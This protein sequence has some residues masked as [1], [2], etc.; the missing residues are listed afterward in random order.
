MLST[1][2]FVYV[3]SLDANSDRQ[4][5]LFRCNNNDT[6]Q[7][8]YGSTLLGRKISLFTDYSKESAN[9]KR[10]TYQKLV[11]TDEMTTIRFETS[12]SF[13]FYYTETGCDVVC[14]QFYI[15]VNPQLKVGSGANTQLLDLNAIQCQTVLTKSLGQFPTWKSKLEV[16]HKTGYNMIHF[17]PIQELG[18]SNSSYSLADQL[19]LNPIFNTKE[20]ECRVEDVQQFIEWL[21]TEWQILSLTDIVLNHTANESPWLQTHPE[22]AFNCFNS[23]WLRPA[24]LLDRILYRMTTDIVDDRWKSKGLTTEVNSEDHL[25]LIRK[26]LHEEYL[27]I[28]NIHELY[29]VDIDTTLNEFKEFLIK[30]CKTSKPEKPLNDETLKLEI[31]VDDKYRRFKSTIDLNIALKIVLNEVEFNGDND[32]WINWSTDN[33]R[34]KLTILNEV[35]TNEIRHHLSDAIENVIKTARYERIDSWGPKHKIISL[36]CPLVCNYFTHKGS[37]MD[38]LDEQKLAFD[39][40]DSK[41][42]MAHNGWVMGDDPLRNFAEKGCNV[43]IRRELIAWGDSVKLNYGSGPQDCP[44]LWSHM[45]KYVTQMA[46]IF[47]GLRLDNCH[48]TPIH[49]AQ[50]LIDSA[51][52]V[53]PNLYLIAELF[54][55]HEGLDNIFVNKLGINSLIREGLSAHDSHDLGRQVYRFGGEPIGAFPPERLS[56]GQSELLVLPL[57]PSVCHAIFFDVTHDN[58]SPIIKRSAYDPLASSALV[59]MTFSAIG[60]NRGHDELVPHHIN[61]VHETREYKSWKENLDSDDK[62]IANNSLSM[63][64][65]IIKSKLAFN[66]LHEWLAVNGYS[67]QFVDQR[68]FDTVAVT[69]HNPET[70]ESVVLVAR[71]AFHCPKDPKASPYLPPLR[72]DGIIDK[73]LFETHMTG[74]PEI[75]FVQ[76]K[77]YINGYSEIRSDIRTDLALDDSKLIKANKIGDSYEIIFNYFP[78][79]AVIAFKVSLSDYHKNALEKLRVFS[80][81]LD[82]ESSDVNTII[83]NLS[84]ID[85]NYLLF[86]C[87]HEEHDDTNGGA[88]S[89]PVFGQMNYCGIASIIYYLRHIR[90]HNDL[91]H[92][93]CGNLR[94]GNWLMDYI[95]DRLTKNPNTKSFADWLAKVFTSLSQIPRYLIPRYFDSIITRI[96]TSILDQIWNQSSPFVR[97]GSRFVQLLALGGVAMIGTNKTAVLPPLSSKIVDESQLLATIAAGLPHFSSGYMRCW[98]R[99]T[100]IA[101][102][103]L[104]LLTGRFT[105]AKHIILGFAGTLR[106]GLIPNLLD[107]GR[108]SRYNARDAVWWWLQAV[109]D[110]CLIAPNGLELLSQS[111]RRLYPTDDS[112]ALLASSEIV[113][114]PL[115]K[116]VQEALQRHYDGID[117][118]ERNAGKQIDEHMTA[119]GFHIKVGVSRETGFVYGGNRFNCGTWMDK[120]G[121][122]AKAENKGLPSTPRDGSAIELIGLS[123]SVVTYL[124]DLS[125]DNKYPFK[126]VNESDGTVFTFREWGLKIEAN[127]EKHLY[128]SAD[129]EQ[130]YVNRQHIYKDTFG[131]SIPWMDFQLRPNCL[132]AMVV[133]PELFDK[134]HAIEALKIVRQELVGPLGIKTL[135]PRDLKYNGVYDNSNDSHNK[136]LAHGANY[137]NGPEWLWPTGYY[138]EALLKFNDNYTETVAYIESLLS[139]HFQHIESSDWFGLPELTNT[140]GKHCPHSCPI[141]AWSHSTI[142]QVLHSIHSK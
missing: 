98:G 113:E 103:G 47:H 20:K 93:L 19:K 44:F 40:N 94:D 45:E 92:P 88:Y 106:H 34:H 136:D 4:S 48:S 35:M 117:F 54:T 24:Y 26:I 65:A 125:D 82:D 138:L 107:G 3:L 52:R 6:I 137:H 135:D 7:F 130:Q 13:H 33:I 14:G 61:V 104:L 22:C 53:N 101:L 133:A 75:N 11:F 127:F 67:H 131:A 108:N 15:V 77:E 62:I 112:P 115:Y 102:K 64:S 128:I 9:F 31:I 80:K 21:R 8:I 110:Y 69:R 29:L 30:Y 76:H 42:L 37:D 25:N 2:R 100:F 86:R 49:V 18:G 66:K 85:L 95:V 28:L 23:P 36:K 91:G 122:S 1:G 87:N 72:I 63:D 109:K 97:N 32:Q 142:L 129:T 51:R 99:D 59:A 27:P 68:D 12:G 10:N 121:S 105:E 90:T 46:T 41:F 43:Y 73:L 5:T 126:G 89:L 139:N 55:A 120:M 114:E 123:K 16:S 38:L 50:H 140:D 118:V 96:Y 84:L 81:Q 78:Q 70:H 57:R 71:T 134:N 119:E 132:V 39:D 141:Q 124:A 111:V 116:T 60:S 83:S 74:E 58:E 56:S 79:S 17:T